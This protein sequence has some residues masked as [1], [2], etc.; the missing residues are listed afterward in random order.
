LYNN[1]VSDVE[2]SGKQHSKKKKI[3]WLLI[4]KCMHTN[5]IIL[6]LPT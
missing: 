1:N 4:E 6:I 3:Y 5:R 2:H